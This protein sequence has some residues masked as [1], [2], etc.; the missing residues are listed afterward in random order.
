MCSLRTPRPI[1][2]STSRPTYRWIC[3]A[4]YRPTLDRYIGRHQDRHIGRGVRKLHMILSTDVSTDTRYYRRIYR[5]IYRPIYSMKY[6]DTIGEV[7]MKYRRTPTISTDRSVGRCSTNIW[8]D[9]QPNI[10]RYMVDTRPILGRVSVEIL[11]D[12]SVAPPP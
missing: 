11:T 2:R 9:T 7:S 6:R 3:R 12:T 4:R 1:C 5:S 8:T 10:D